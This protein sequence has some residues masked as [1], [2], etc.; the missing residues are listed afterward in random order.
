L[1]RGGPDR[2]A[3]RRK[4]PAWLADAWTR[5]RVLVVCKGK[6]VVHGE[7]ARL[8]F[9]APTEAPAGER[10]FLGLGGTLGTAGIET[11][12]FAVSTALSSIDELR[13]TDPSLPDLRLAGLRQVGEELPDDEVALM[14]TAV[15]L[16]NWH[17]RH[18]YSPVSGRATTAGEAGWTRVTD[19]GA[20]TLWPRTDPAVIT[21]VHDDV[22]GPQGRCLLGHKS[23][24]TSTPGWGRRYS[25]LAGFV[26]PGESAE[27]T[28]V[29]EVFEEVG[30]RVGKIRYVASQPWP[31]PA[32]L[33]LGF[34]AVGD[35]AAEIRVDADE[36]SD[37]RWFTR[38]E[39]A[40]ALAGDE[41]AFSL[42]YGLSIASY[43]IAEWLA[44]R[45]PNTSGP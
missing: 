12:Y 11:P 31:F 9:V 34:T 20:E 37:A 41:E 39:I 8:A 21:L 35:P 26:E 10:L 40:A 2:A 24:W 13:R 44:D 4:D 30:V 23:E 15:A 22:P 14:V 32:S 16:D 6:V 43:L 29:R 25:C 33:M 7:P 45:T 19:D 27:A 5:S 17:S 28:V 36:I 1:D 3:E 18:P 38:T 42:P